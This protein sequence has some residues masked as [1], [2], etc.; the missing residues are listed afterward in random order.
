MALYVRFRDVGQAIGLAMQLWFFATPIVFAVNAVHGAVRVALAFNPLT[1]VVDGFRWALVDADPPVL[2]DLLSAV[3][4]VAALVLGIVCFQHM[5]R[6]FA[7][8]I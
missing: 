4:G 3:C 8:V 7:D 5:A 2:L 6:R 1:A